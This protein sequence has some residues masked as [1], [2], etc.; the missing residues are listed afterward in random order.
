MEDRYGQCSNFRVESFRQVETNMVGARRS[1]HG[2]F[3][4]ADP[5]LA[6]HYVGQRRVLA[7]LLSFSGEADYAC[8]HLDLVA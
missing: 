8:K 5:S 3:F 2:H 1:W 6:R 7:G 4:Y